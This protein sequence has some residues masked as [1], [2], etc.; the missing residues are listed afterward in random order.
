MLTI[1]SSLEGL[2]FVVVVVVVVVVSLVL[3]SG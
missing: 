2:L 1:E 3:A